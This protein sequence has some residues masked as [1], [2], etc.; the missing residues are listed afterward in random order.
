MAKFSELGVE[1]DVI[2]G[3]GIDIDELFG[4]RILIEKTIIQPTNFPGKNSSGLRMQMQVCLVTFLENGDY[5]KHADGTPDGERRSCFTG[6]DILIG[7]IQKAE[8]NLPMI[9]QDREKRGLAPLRLYPMDTTIVKVG[10][11]FQFT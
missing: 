11:C 9:N 4:R 5:V 6:S 2:I 1:S 3:K 10:K 7:A 8:T